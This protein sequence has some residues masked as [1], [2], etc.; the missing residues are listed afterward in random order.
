[1]K[2]LGGG[3][4][5][6]CPKCEVIREC[7]VPTDLGMEKS[8][9]YYFSGSSGE[10]YFRR[11]RECITCATIFETYE[12]E[13]SSPNLHSQSKWRDLQG[14]VQSLEK[15]LSAIS[16]EV[17]KKLDTFSNPKKPQFPI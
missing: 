8:G 7:R 16:K 15:S 11:N 2:S 9:N 4:E 13:S 6:Y 1:M 3:T 12:V 10:S 5:M 14:K 17:E